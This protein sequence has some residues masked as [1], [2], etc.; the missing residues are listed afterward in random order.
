MKKTLANNIIIIAIFFMIY[1]PLMFLSLYKMEYTVTSP[2][3]NDEVEGFIKLETEYEQVGS[4]HTTSVF[5][6]DEIIV[7]FLNFKRKHI[8][9][10]ISQ[11]S[12]IGFFGY[13]NFVNFS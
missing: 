3:Y 2:G 10:L 8:S 6:I 12:Y 4:F 13:F 7:N 9:Y 11:L 1:S 5:V